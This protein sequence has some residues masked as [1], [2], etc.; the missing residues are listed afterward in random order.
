VHSKNFQVEAKPMLEDER[1]MLCLELD[2]LTATTADL[3]ITQTGPTT[4]RCDQTTTQASQTI[5]QV[6]PTTKTQGVVAP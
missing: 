3:T 5:T 2:D 4:N 1:I 6:G